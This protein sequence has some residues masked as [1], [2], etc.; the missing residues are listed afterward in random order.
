LAIRHTSGKITDVLYNA[1]VYRNEAGDVEGVFAAARDI[2][3]RKEAERN[4]KLAVE[5]TQVI[6]WEMDIPRQQLKFDLNM[7]P[8]L[9]LEPGED[10]TTLTA[11]LQRVHPADAGF[12]M[13]RFQAA[14]EPRNAIFD[15]EYRLRRQDGK[16]EWVHTRGTVIQHNSAGQAEFAVGTTMNI[17]AR[18]RT[19]VEL[20]QHRN[21]LATMVEERTA[22]LQV[23]KEAAEA[24]NVAKS[25]FLANMSHEIRT[26]M[27]GILGMAHLIRRGGLT[28][29]QTKR[30]D[31]LQV[32]SEYLLNVINAILELS[33][34]EAG[35]FGL[36]ETSVS[37]E[38]IVVNITSLLN[39]RLQAKHLELHTVIDTLPDNLVGDAT[40]VQ[41]ALLNYAGNAVKFTESGSITLRVRLV[42]E[43]E[44]SALIRLEV[45]DTGIGIAPEVIPKLF[46]AF[47]Q[48][49]SSSTRKYGGTGL[50]LAITKRIAQLMGG[51]AGAESLIG[52]G[53][54]F[55]FTLRLKK[56]N[57][58]KSSTAAG[59]QPMVEEIL[60]RDYHGTRILLVEDEPVNR[61]VAQMTL[62]DVGMVV[63]VA[64]DGNAALHLAGENDYAV[65][66]MDMQMPVMDGLEATRQLRQLPRY[67][68]IPILAMT[69]NAFA[70]DKEKCFASG[71]NDFIAKPVRP[72]LL[73]ATLL[74]WLSCGQAK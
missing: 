22:E 31:T 54:T 18:K 17:S 24:A 64:E 74:E 15:L 7:L 5:V 65:I 25:A 9:G 63:D 57:G 55:W 11:W 28:P 61:E 27:N 23:A 2:T 13:E 47:E 45:Q 35:K 26:P 53:S 42:E 68:R 20:Q 10:L 66:L 41:Q 72:K 14:L 33:K 70:E 21:H 38:G 56:G 69:A 67:A 6:L 46:T 58:Y 50:G 30:M 51:D 73:Y 39:D 8:V 49:D 19:E 4:L 12:F 16:Y 37:I 48:A 1:T 60:K 59:Q 32:S 3:E 71:M 43:D 44:A 36:D 62:T 34:I 40:R 29:E 52:V